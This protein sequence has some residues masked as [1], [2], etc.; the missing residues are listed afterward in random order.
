MDTLQKIVGALTISLATGTLA[1]HENLDFEL[2]EPGVAF[3]ASASAIDAQTLQID[4]AIADGYYLYHDKFRFTST[5]AGITLG[6]PLIP[7]GQVKVDEFFGEVETHRNA[8][9]IRVPYTAQADTARSLTFLAVSQGCADIGVCYP[10]FE[11]NLT[12]S[13]AALTVTQPN[14]LS[15][16]LSLTGSGD[17][18][19]VMLDFYADWCISCKEMEAFTFSD[20]AVKKRLANT[21]L[22]QSD[23]TANDELDQAL[24]KHFA[25]FGPPAILFFDKNGR[26]IANSRVV[27]F[28]SADR[29]AT[30]IDRIFM[31]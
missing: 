5:T 26:E 1:N 12:V 8:I 29:F 3:G 7:A 9:S 13:L 27:G 21:T 24:L 14:S 11:Q 18:Q 4:F 31:N 28:M 30:H 16:L 25:I 6:D 15:Q 20:P 17:N 22:L 10:P 19:R 2:L 23:V